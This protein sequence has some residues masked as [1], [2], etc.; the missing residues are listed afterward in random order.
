M[1]ETKL[2]ALKKQFIKAVKRFEEVLHERKNKIIRDSAIKRFE[3]TF[4]L[5][6][7][8]IKAYLEDEEGIYCVSPK[9]CF[10]Q[11]HRTGLIDYDERWIEMTN[12]RNFAVHTYDEKFA[13]KLYKE[14]PRYLECFKN[15]EK[16]VIGK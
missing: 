10:R 1:S 11:S 9:D 5:S 4:D 6:W 13:D 12:E 7:R 15:L 16:S 8:L 3:F 14:L 2:E